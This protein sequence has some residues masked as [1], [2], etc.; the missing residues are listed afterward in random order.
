MKSCVIDLVA[1]TE[2]RIVKFI[3][4]ITSLGSVAKNEAI[5]ILKC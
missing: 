4:T 3:A 1:L 2:T 5:L